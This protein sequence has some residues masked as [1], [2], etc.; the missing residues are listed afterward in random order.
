MGDVQVWM[1]DEDSAAIIINT[2]GE[3]P[4]LL[5]ESR[6]VDATRFSDGV[7]ALAFN[8]LE[9]PVEREKTLRFVEEL[10]KTMAWAIEDMCRTGESLTAGEATM[11][12]DRLAAPFTNPGRRERIVDR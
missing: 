8:H 10:N 1:P 11:I 12:L 7:S 9:D 2:A 3:E 4:W 5:A 6:Q